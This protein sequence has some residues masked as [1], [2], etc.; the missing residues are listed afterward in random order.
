MLRGILKYQL[1]D[2]KLFYE[3]SQR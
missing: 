3:H 1:T 2:A